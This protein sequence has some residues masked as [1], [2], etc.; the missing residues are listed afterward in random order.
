MR[1]NGWEK[2]DEMKETCGSGL[3][4]EI[5]RREIVD[6]KQREERKGRCV[7]YFRNLLCTVPL[8]MH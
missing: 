1:V 4:W 7:L 2:R 3:K 6:R 5:G 8:D